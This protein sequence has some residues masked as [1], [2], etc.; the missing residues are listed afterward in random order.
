MYNRE[1][2]P[3]LQKVV[4]QPYDKISPEMQAR[5]YESSPYNSVRIVRGK[6]YSEDN[7]QN[8][9]YTRAQDTYRQWCA[10][11]ILKPV[12]RPAFYAYTQRYAVPGSPSDVCTRK[13]F[14]GAGQLEEYANRVVFPHERTLM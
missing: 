5:Y 3:D 13:G 1:R 8:N 11:S 12:A 14:I 2:I 4:T 10:E 9:V 7:P 6:T